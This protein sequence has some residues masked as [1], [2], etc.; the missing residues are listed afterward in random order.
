[1]ADLRRRLSE[2]SVSSMREER[3]ERRD[4]KVESELV[5]GGSGTLEGDGE[6]AGASAFLFLAACSRQHTIIKGDDY[7]FSHL[8]PRHR[9]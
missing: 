2:D 5:G 7:D 9:P 3:E 6:G 4:D 1:M 8:F